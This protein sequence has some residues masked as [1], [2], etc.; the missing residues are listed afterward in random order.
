MTLQISPTA[1]TLADEAAR[2]LAATM[3]AHPR[4]LFCLAAGDTPRLAYQRLTVRLR[5]EGFD[6]SGLRFVALDEWRGL[7]PDAPGGCQKFLRDAVFD[8]LGVDPAQVAFFDAQATDAEAEC[9]RIDRW[10][11]DCGPLVTAVLGIGMNGHLGFN[12]PG[13]PADSVTRP[14]DLDAVT[15][16]VGTKYFAG[17]AP[18]QGLTLGLGTLLAA[19][20]VILLATGSAK[21]SIVRSALDPAQFPLVP[22]A[23]LNRHPRA[24]FLVDEEAG[25]LV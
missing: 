15:Q 11:Q 7:A 10:I 16:R 14:V 24:L 3:T 21:A 25:R 1:E 22:A 23:V 5:T 18:S 17:R 6:A 19:R 12:E 2:I 20:E 4:G 8:P 13:T 9:R